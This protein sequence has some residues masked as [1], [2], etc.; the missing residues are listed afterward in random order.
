MT[1]MHLFAAALGTVAV[2]SGSSGLA[3]RAVTS[4]APQATTQAAGSPEFLFEQ[5]KRLSDAFQYDQ[6]APICTAVI[7]QL[8]AGG[9][10]PTQ[11]QK[12]DLL[13]QAYVLRA[14]AKFSLGD[15]LGT[16]Q[17]FSALLGVQ[18]S[19]KLSGISPRLVSIFEQVRKVT[20][21]Q[22]A[23]SLTP[24]G[25]VDIDGR[26]YTLQADPQIIDLTAG[27][28]TI[29]ATRTGYQPVTQK[30]TI[31]ASQVSPLALT[32]E[33]SSSTL[34]VVSIPDGIEVVL[35]G[36]SKGK[37]QRTTGSEDGTASLLLTDLQTGSHKLQLRRDCYTSVEQ[38]VTI[39][40]PGD[41]RTDPLRLTSTV[42]T[43]HVTASEPGA[44]IF[45]DGVAKGQAPAEFTDVCAGSHLIE[46]RGAT[47]RFIDRR[48]WKTGDNT[49]I[50]ATLRSAF[51]IVSAKAGSGL[52]ADQVRTNAE[53]ALT[54]AKQVLLYSPAQADL[55]GAM[56]GES[57]PPDWLIVESGA[58]ADGPPRVPRDVTRDLGKKL[59]TKFG[60][61][62][63]AVISP[64]PDAY[65]FFVSLLATGSGEPDVITVAT[66]DAAAR[67]AAMARLDSAV[68]P[69][70]RPSIETS[71]VDIVEGQGAY[72]ARPG[73]TGA[74]AGLVA[75]D[76]VVGAGGQPVKSVADLRARI[77]AVK[78]PA[79]DLVLNVKKAGGD[80]RSVTVPVV[81]VPDAL[82]MRDP[83]LL[84]NRLLI[85]LQDAAK[86][87]RTP[88]ERSAA[89]LNLA[90]V[91][92]RLGNFDDAQASLNDA[93]LPD[94]AG[95]SSGT[96][97]YLQGL[98]LE[99]L[100]R[101][102]D[103]QAAFTKAA[104]AAQARLSSEGPLVAP[105]AKQK[106][107]RAGK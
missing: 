15:S 70:V 57:L 104:A 95:V 17:D 27:E 10:V 51:P 37:T 49:T 96:V 75:G 45:I 68:P 69:L 67:T 24:A 98:C 2:I 50:A 93:H 11:P 103:A 92:M 105:L 43:A 22:I 100:G 78:P 9:T 48:D 89:A 65:T 36:T 53:R 77:A 32:L 102:A 1:R 18:P 20:V 107:S 73:G 84:Y 40:Q 74:K 5:A 42:A 66:G 8:T 12:L 47:G 99:A 55:D 72:V 86:V 28:H 58:P 97:A 26:P 59:A 13:V 106:L 41:L 87:A 64:G 35:D 101:G 4:T 90:I 62:G 88:A 83:G 7:A 19:F 33:R 21:G 61:Q 16:E 79:G 56:K 52:T 76:I 81:F 30:F 34:T 25:A 80:A 71:F 94:G 91:Q 3:A 82:P 38:T 63:I 46:V 29:T 14:R 23:A 39:D 60:T 54:T 6:A 85:G 31:V 44:A